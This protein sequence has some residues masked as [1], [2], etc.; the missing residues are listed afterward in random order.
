QHRARRAAGAQRT[1]HRTDRRRRARAPGDAAVRRGTADEPRV[2]APAVRRAGLRAAA[3]GDRP[4]AAEPGDAGGDRAD[5]VEPR[6]AARD[7][8]PEHGH[9]EG[10][11]RR[12]PAH[13]RLA[14]RRCRAEGA[15]M[16]APTE[17]PTVVED[18]I[19]PVYGGIATRAVGLAIDSVIIWVALLILGAV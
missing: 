14:R 15:R 11:G 8:R 10:T 5:R 3:P 9:G 12:R 1:R 7:R 16:A 17:A 4:R 19:A 13:Q 18:E 6:V 2:R